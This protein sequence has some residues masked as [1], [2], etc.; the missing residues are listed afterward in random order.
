MK[1]LNIIIIGSSS[2]LGKHLALTYAKYQ[3]VDK[4]QKL[5]IVLVARRKQLLSDLKKKLE[6]KDR[7]ILII[8]Q[9]ISDF[10]Q[11][12]NYA[13][14]NIINKSINFFKKKNKINNKIDHLICNPA[15]L[16]KSSPKDVNLNKNKYLWEKMYK[17]N[18]VGQKR[19]IDLAIKKNF[20]K[21]KGV[22]AITNSIEGA[23]YI[24]TPDN[25]FG[26]YC[27]TKKLLDKWVNTELRSKHGSKYNI[28][29][30]YPSKIANPSFILNILEKSGK[31][32]K[33]LPEWKILGQKKEPY[34]NFDEISLE[35]LALRYY[36]AILNKKKIEYSSITDKNI[37]SLPE[38]FCGWIFYTWG[39][40]KNYTI[41]DLPFLILEIP[42]FLPILF[43]FIINNNYLKTNYITKKDI[44]E[45]E[46]ELNY[47]KFNYKDDAFIYYR[48]III[49]LFILTLLYYTYFGTNSKKKLKMEN[50]IKLKN[51]LNNI[52]K[53]ILNIFISCNFKTKYRL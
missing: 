3:S 28:L 43:Q 18:F 17:T 50:E 53:K 42:S 20:I 21:Y 7:N 25:N 31:K 32:T 14:E 33:P 47:K 52:K 9:D 27:K 16:V 38:P 40:L 2:G 8:E 24:P 15:I 22:I 46:Y 36:L 44:K 41:F 49:N 5:N 13:A 30:L 29:S 26:T 37:F 6:R 11:K 39:I 1:D 45:K 34:K 48:S 4:K 23:R 12:S 51:K 35:E 10:D 19:I